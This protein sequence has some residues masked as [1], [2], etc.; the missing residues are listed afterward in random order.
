MQTL[1]G[2]LAPEWDTVLASEQATWPRLSRFP[3]EADIPPSYSK[4]TGLDYACE[5][6]AHAEEKKLRINADNSTLPSLSHELTASELLRNRYC[7][8][9]HTVISLHVCFTLWGL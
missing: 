6:A 7:K 8:N 5:A 9:K 4:A 3:S 2:G 1:K